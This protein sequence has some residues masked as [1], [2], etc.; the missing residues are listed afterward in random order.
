MK[1]TLILF[2]IVAIAFANDRKLGRFGDRIKRL[3]D[4]IE[5]VIEEVEKRIDQ[6]EI[7][8]QIDQVLDFVLDVTNDADGYLV[9]IDEISTG[10]STGIRNVTC[11][12]THCMTEVFGC[13]GDKV[14]RENFQCQGKCGSNSTC[15]FMCSESYKSKAQDSLMYCM[16]ESH[17][18]LTLPDPAPIDNATCRDP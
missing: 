7:N 18:C 3:V 16:F 4:K 11:I 12:T 5:N 14:C 9:M 17:H 15:T 13:M 2:A 6:N 10:V 8:S 1:I